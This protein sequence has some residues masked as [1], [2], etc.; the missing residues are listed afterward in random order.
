MKISWGV[1]EFSGVN[2]D[3]PNLKQPLLKGYINS[4][5]AWSKIA[6]ARKQVLFAP[7][8]TNCQCANLNGLANFGAMIF[9]SF[10]KVEFDISQTKLK[11]KG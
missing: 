4:G 1:P 7:N 6:H 11:P 8:Q 10:S 3:A 5:T 2:T 9:A